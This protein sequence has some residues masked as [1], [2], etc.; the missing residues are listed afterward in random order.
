MEIKAESRIFLIVAPMGGPFLLWK[1]AVLWACWF[2]VRTGSGVK[3]A[4]VFTAVTEENKQENSDTRTKFKG[5]ILFKFDYLFKGH[6]PDMHLKC[7]YKTMN[8]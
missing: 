8:G 4:S 1:E 3:G 7:Q 5:K 6:F 2:S